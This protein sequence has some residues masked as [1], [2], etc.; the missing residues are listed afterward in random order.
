MQLS[1]EKVELPAVK[2]GY[3]CHTQSYLSLKALAKPSPAYI[4]TGEA[5]SDQVNSLQTWATLKS[6]FSLSWT[7]LRGCET[8][9]RQ[10]LQRAYIRHQQHAREVFLEYLDRKSR[11]LRMDKPQTQITID[12]E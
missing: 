11:S 5:G 3:L 9:P 2:T 12:D 1:A 8:H 4:C 10:A 6:C 7:M